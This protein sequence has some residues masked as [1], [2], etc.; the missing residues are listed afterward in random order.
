[1]ASRGGSGVLRHT[2]AGDGG[3]SEKPRRETVAAPSK[4]A[5]VARLEREVKVYHS[6]LHVVLL[7]AALK[8]S[9]TS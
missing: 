2:S 4:S 6:Y 5:A 3:R 1:M 8:L 7:S 9:M